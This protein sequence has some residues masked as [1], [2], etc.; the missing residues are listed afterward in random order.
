MALGIFTTPHAGGERV[1]SAPAEAGG[2]FG[3][4]SLH[5]GTHLRH[6]TREHIMETSIGITTSSQASRHDRTDEKTG[7]G[8]AIRPFRRAA[9]R[10][11]R[12]RRGWVK[13]SAAIAALGLVGVVSLTAC[14]TTNPNPGPPH[15]AAP[16]T[17]APKP[18]T[19]SIQPATPAPTDSTGLS[20]AGSNAVSNAVSSAEFAQQVADYVVSE[21]LEAEDGTTATDAS[22]DPATVSDPSDPSL[23]ASVSCDI[24]Y[25]DG[26]VWQQTLVI[27][28]DSSGN[29]SDITDNDSIELS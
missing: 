17:S 20:D 12:A 1:N 16:A 11:T 22:C 18:S 8:S 14:G 3:N 7:R 15:T 5:G 6:L 23:P 10:G 25:S 27:T 19:P 24:T 21:P 9:G 29:M 13:G 4:L 28:F 2:D 26:S